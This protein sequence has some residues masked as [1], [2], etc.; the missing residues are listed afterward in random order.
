[1]VCFV[2]PT[3]HVHRVLFKFNADDLASNQLEYP[4]AALDGYLTTADWCEIIRLIRSAPYYDDVTPILN[5]MFDRESR[6]DPDKG[7][8]RC[9]IVCH[10]INH[11]DEA[12]VIEYRIVINRYI[13]EIARINQRSC[14][15][16]TLCFER[17][18]SDEFTS[19]LTGALPADEWRELIQRINGQLKQRRSFIRQWCFPLQMFCAILLP[20]LTCLCSIVDLRHRQALLLTVVESEIRAINKQI[21]AYGLQIRHDPYEHN[22]W[23]IIPCLIVFKCTVMADLSERTFVIPN[24]NSSLTQSE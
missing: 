23:N 1:M 17:E 15:Q 11:R 14:G 9:R 19:D 18:Y 2:S 3:A 5:D 4:S 6:C 21:N 24:T 7:T 13:N 16:C 20:P 10:R 22:S 12:D 8:W